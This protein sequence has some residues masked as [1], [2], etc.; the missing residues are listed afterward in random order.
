MYC[1]EES[2]RLQCKLEKQMSVLVEVE[3]VSE[4]GPGIW[5]GRLAPGDLQVVAGEGPRVGERSIVL[6][7]RA[8]MIENGTVLLK[9]EDFSVLGYGKQDETV[10]LAATASDD[11]GKSTDE[12]FYASNAFGTGDTEFLHLTERLLLGDMKLAAK[13]LLTQVR[14]KSAGDLKRGK[15]RN[16]S[17]T[18]DNFWYVIVQPQINELSITVRGDLEHFRNVSSLEIKDDRGNTRF[19]IRSSN[20]VGE[21]IKLIFHAKRKI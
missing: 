4:V 21:A 10:L 16:F 11:T 15:S 18:P 7:H 20:D 5:L 6:L 12:S 19:K 1:S 13:E 14:L 2:A 8:L 9:R 3:D 17:N